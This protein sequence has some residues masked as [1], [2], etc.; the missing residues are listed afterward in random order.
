MRQFKHDSATIAYNEI[1][2]GD[3]LIFI[4][5]IYGESAAYEEFLRLLARRYRVIAPDLPM[6][7]N[8]SMPRSKI[9]ISDMADIIRDLARIRGI[10]EPI[11]CGHSAGTLVA[12]EYAS[13]HET[14]KLILIEP[15]ADVFGSV[16]HL[17]G[18]LCIKVAKETF[19]Y[20]RKGLSI[21]RYTS[22][23][24]LRNIFNPAYYSLIRENLHYAGS[25]TGD[26]TVF[27]AEDDEL[28]PFRKAFM[29]RFPKARLIRVKGG[30]DWPITR[31]DLAKKIRT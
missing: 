21:I 27:W 29:R 9:S 31:P 5:G 22:K 17:L 1:G 10:R 15:A 12:M 3:P 14:R 2:D 18:R 30:H 8:S 13:R 25:W 24:F 16:P 11:I 6:N 19:R 28:I 7:G 23:N 26:T 20:P 4:H